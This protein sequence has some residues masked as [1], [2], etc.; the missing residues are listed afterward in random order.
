MKTKHIFYSI[1]FI[2]IL[3]GCSNNTK[4]KKPVN[5]NSIVKYAENFSISI[6][7]NYIDFQIL[8]PE[9]NEVEK[10]YALVKNDTIKVPEGY[11]PILVP[12]KSVIALSSTHIGMLSK[13]DL[14]NLVKGISNHTY[15]HEP[16]ILDRY[17]KGEIIEMGEENSIPVE[18]IIRSKSDLL[19]YSGFGKAFPH[20]EQLE[21]LG[22][23]CLAN[24]D[25]K[26]NHPLGKAEW[27]K[28]FGYLTGKENSASI[29]FKI[30][31]KDYLRL[32]KIAS[33]LKS[34]PTLFSGNLVG[35]IW[36]SPAGESYNAILFKDAKGDYK[37]ANTKGTGSTE[38][39]F[40]Q[41]FSDNVNTKYWFNPGVESKKDLLKSQPKFKLF[42]AYKQN[43]IFSY[44]FSGNEFW[45]R[46]AIEP[47]HVLSDLIRILHPELKLKNK[48]YFYRTLSK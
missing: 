42:Q 45:E 21:K 17:K 22:T 40:E 16:S 30:I 43:N 14:C 27:I 28:V 4:K 35:D 8:N 33:K 48:L 19:I 44:T 10:K 47:N 2:S 24:Y 34:T 20:Q 41:I 18:S 3:F 39:S 31:E 36:Y 25:W 37:Y 46:S 11:T 32:K 13:L 26:E 29:Y 38:N 6:S 15:I 7:E 9:T 5:S 12:I 23:I 1:I